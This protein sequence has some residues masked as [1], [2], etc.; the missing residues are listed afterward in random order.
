MCLFYLML[1]HKFKQ[2]LCKLHIV[3]GYSPLG[4]LPMLNLSSTV[5]FLSFSLVIR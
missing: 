3:N 5:S 2:I 4:V 1:I